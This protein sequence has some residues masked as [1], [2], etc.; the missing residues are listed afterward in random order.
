M[1]IDCGEK[2]F[3]CPTIYTFLLC[4]DQPDGSS[5]TISTEIHYCPS[6]TYCDH[7]YGDYECDSPGIPSSTTTE[8]MYN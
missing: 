3:F 6:G 7:N 2:D 8:S 1:S 5:R 4:A